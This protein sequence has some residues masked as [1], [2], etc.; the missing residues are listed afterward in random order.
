MARILNIVN[1]SWYDELKSVAYYSEGEFEA[2]ILQ[3][4]SE[5]FPYHFVFP[6]KRDITD[7]A[8]KAT[9]R[10]DLGLITKDF[11]DWALVE[12]EIEKHSLDHVLEQTAVFLDGEY[13]AAALAEYVKKQL[14]DYCGKSASLDRLKQLFLAKAPRILVILDVH[15]PKWEKKLNEEGVDLCVFEVYK[16]VAGHYVYRT[17]GQYPTMPVEEAHCRSTMPNVLEVVGN[18][19]FKK[20][21][22]GSRVEVSFDDLLTRWVLIEDK[23]KRY[24]RLEGR[25]NPL[26]PKATYG[27]VRDKANKYS[28]KRS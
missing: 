19:Q 8:G 9:K 17:F 21:G 3:H 23:G 22:K 12:V 18:F 7:Q 20:L 15:D 4:A 16:N 27:L 11:S 1:N 5:V 25:S 24:L 13:N 10:P 14:V 2:R 28:F 26:S 6:F